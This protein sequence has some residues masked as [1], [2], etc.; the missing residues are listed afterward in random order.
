MS[1]QTQT[2]TK[3]HEGIKAFSDAK[4]EPTKLC[5]LGGS[6]SNHIEN[7]IQLCPVCVQSLTLKP[8]NLIKIEKHVNAH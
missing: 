6:I 3:I 4:Q 1:L 7:L 8:V 5:G 2:L